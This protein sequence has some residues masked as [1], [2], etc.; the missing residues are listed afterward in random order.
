MRKKFLPLLLLI[1]CNI[2][3]VL[4]TL[5]VTRHAL[6]DLEY[7]IYS[8]RSHFKSLAMTRMADYYYEHNNNITGSELAK[9]LNGTISDQSEVHILATFDTDKNFPLIWIGGDPNFQKYAVNKNLLQ[10]IDAAD[11][12]DIVSKKEFN[13]FIGHIKSYTLP[14]D[15]TPEIVIFNNHIKYLI[16][17]VIIP[18][19]IPGGAKYLYVA[20][21]P[22]TELAFSLEAARGKYTILFSGSILLA[23]IMLVL[24][25]LTVKRFA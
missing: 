5:Y 13:G 10:A 22:A 17:W 21:T 6:Y 15:Y 20:F 18:E 23:G 14:S 12:L 3:L 1:V 7:S 11:S 2:V 16:T 4:G 24:I 19:P 9:F 25:P 8:Q